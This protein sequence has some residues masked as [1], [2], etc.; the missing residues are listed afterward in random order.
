M[1]RGVNEYTTTSSSLQEWHE[2]Q[3][4]YAA[5]SFQ[6]DNLAS[7]S[8]CGALAMVHVAEASSPPYS[9]LRQLALFPAAAIAIIDE[10]LPPEF[11]SSEV[12]PNLILAQW[13]D[14]ESRW[15]RQPWAQLLVVDADDPKLVAEAMTFGEIP[16]IS[17]RFLRP[18]TDLLTAR[19]ACDALQRDLAPLGQFAGYVV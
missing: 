15:P 7:A 2:V 1:L 10:P 18:A 19:A 16:M 4:A 8:E 11:R 6:R 5:D 17:V 13:I 12:A 14:A 9:R 3:A